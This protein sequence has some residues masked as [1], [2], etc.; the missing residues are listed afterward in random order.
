MRIKN[1]AV[2]FSILLL[3][4]SCNNRGVNEKSSSIVFSASEVDKKLDVII[5]GQLFTS[6]CWPD[7]VYKPILYPVIT[8]GGT[9]ITRGFP[10]NPKAGERNDHIHQVGI[11]LNYGNVNGIDFW[12]NGYRG[13]QEPEGGVIKHL[14][15]E[16]LTSKNGEGS[17]TSAEEWLDHS[18]Q[19]LLTERTEYHF[20][21]KGSIRI[22]DRITK[23]TAEDTAVVFKDTKEGMFAIRV[24]RQLELASD[25]TITILNSEG[26][27]IIV[28]NSLNT[29]CTGN[30]RSSEGLSGEEVWG[31]RAKWMVLDGTIDNEKISIAVCDHNKNPGYPAYWHARGYGLFSANPLGWSDF[32]EGAERMGFT[33]QPKKSAVFRYRM[34]ISS[35]SYLTDNEIDGFVSEFNRKYK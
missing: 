18:G 25:D 33:I 31:T 12:G 29:S 30:Y 3:S 21:A 9:E 14:R 19:R 13:F 23:L 16:R 17:F 34:V 8:S 20:I 15:F 24:A 27:P 22:I 28:S 1:T 32:T 26:N 2:F 7:N 5:D 11:W 4:F 6:F 35:G 10:L